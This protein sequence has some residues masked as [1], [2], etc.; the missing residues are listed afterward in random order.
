MKFQLG[1]KLIIAMHDYQSLLYYMLLY[2]LGRT[3]RHA[4]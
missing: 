1:L 3:H 2:L 4:E